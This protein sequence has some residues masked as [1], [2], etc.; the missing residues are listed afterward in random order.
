M[1]PSRPHDLVARYPA[2]ARERGTTRVAA[3][4]T[5]HRVRHVGEFQFLSLRGLWGESAANHDGCRYDTRRS[6]PV[7]S[8]ESV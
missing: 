2:S 5:A 7:R 8:A 4:N 3:R 6:Q 1:G